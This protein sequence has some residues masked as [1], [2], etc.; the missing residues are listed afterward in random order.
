MIRMRNLN[1]KCVKVKLKN[2]ININNR[3]QRSYHAYG[4]T[5]TII[6]AI[7]QFSSKLNNCIKNKR[8]NIRLNLN[9]VMI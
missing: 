3:R 1:R 5:E 8:Y 4:K 2:T 6:C 7:D 9:K